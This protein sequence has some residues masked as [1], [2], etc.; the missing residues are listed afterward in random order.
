MVR[1]AASWLVNTYQ[2]AGGAGDDERKFGSSEV[3]PGI[4]EKGDLKYAAVVGSQCLPSVGS[5]FAGDRM[6]TPCIGQ[7]VHDI[8]MVVSSPGLMCDGCAWLV[9]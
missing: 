7:L 2:V 1:D 9:W 3:G 5:S 6:F 8:G 4:H